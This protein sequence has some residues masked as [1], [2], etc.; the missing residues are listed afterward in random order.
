HQRI[1]SDAEIEPDPYFTDEEEGNFILRPATHAQHPYSLSVYTNAGVS[2][3]QIGRSTNNRFMIGPL[4]KIDMSMA[5]GLGQ[6][7]MIQLKLY[8]GTKDGNYYT[9]L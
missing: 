5:Q 7:S 2:H 4:D 6:S 3:F 1:M 8:G 9:W